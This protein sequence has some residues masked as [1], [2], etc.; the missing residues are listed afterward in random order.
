MF[1]VIIKN[2]TVIDGT[3]NPRYRADVG[4]KN[5]KIADIGDLSNELTEESIDARGQ[6]VVP[7]F[8]DVNNHSDTYWRIFATPTLDSLVRQGITTIIG[9]NCGSSLAPLVNKD[10]IQ[11]IQKWVDV[12]N[13]SLNWLR[14][15]EF[16]DEVER[17]QL[18]VNFGTLVGHGTLRRGITHDENR[19]LNEVE[20]ESAK[21]MLKDALREGALGMSSGLIYTHARSAT[22]E[23]LIQLAE[24]VSKND[25]V[26]ATHVRGESRGLTS[27]IEEAIEVAKQSGVKLHISHLK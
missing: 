12:S 14:M 16:L 1:N 24:V 21:K 4:I 13:F 10:I 6:L 2:G 3:G 18:S 8:I 22:R 11:S 9:G 20:L 17:K 7:G 26:Y 25:G 19:L 23:E 15:G 27:S 5:G